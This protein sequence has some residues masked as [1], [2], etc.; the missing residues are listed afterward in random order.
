MFESRRAFMKKF[1][2]LVGATAVAAAFMATGSNNAEAKPG[3][4]PATDSCNNSCMYWCTTSCE[5]RCRFMC[6]DA[7]TSCK[8]AAMKD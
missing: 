7:C 5:Y 1:G 8:G 3:E 2:K 6:G 4:Y